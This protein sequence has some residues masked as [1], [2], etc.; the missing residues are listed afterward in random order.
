MLQRESI[1]VQ[2]PYG[3]VQVKIARLGERVVTVTPEFED[4]RRLAEQAG[5]PVKEIYALALGA[6]HQ[7][8]ILTPE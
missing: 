2:T 5:V 4:C 3:E 7:R 1:A 8:S 6:Y